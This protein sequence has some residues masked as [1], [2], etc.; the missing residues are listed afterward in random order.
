MTIPPSLLECY[1]NGT[2]L[3]RMGLPPFGIG[4]LIEIVRK[5]EA[6]PYTRLDLKQMAVQLTHR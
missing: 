2:L 3:S 4:Q 1:A 6:W 5:I